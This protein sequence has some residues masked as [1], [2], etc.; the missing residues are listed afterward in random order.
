MFPVIFWILSVMRN[1]VLQYVKNYQL[2]LVELMSQVTQISL[3]SFQIIL[4][5]VTEM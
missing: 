2:V 3:I 4:A 5:R 1:N